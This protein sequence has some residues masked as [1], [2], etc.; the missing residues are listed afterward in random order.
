MWIWRGL[1][2]E[3]ST[4]GVVFHSAATTARHELEECFYQNKTEMLILQ[5]VMLGTVVT[6]RCPVL[7]RVYGIVLSQKLKCLFC[8]F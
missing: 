2:S 1:L 4:A 5:Y 7:V 6:F 8:F 3:L